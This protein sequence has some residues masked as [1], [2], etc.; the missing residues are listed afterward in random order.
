LESKE[1]LRASSKMTS[2]V[3]SDT[4]TFKGDKIISDAGSDHKVSA[5][6]I[7]IKSKGDMILKGSKISQN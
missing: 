1:K 6:K 7:H 5:A 3:A 4:L 2:L